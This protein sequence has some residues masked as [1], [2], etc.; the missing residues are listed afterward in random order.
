MT[1]ALSVTSTVLGTSHPLGAQELA[2]ACGAEITWVV[3]LVEVGIIESRAP[4]AQVDD[5]RF[6]SADLQSALSVRRLQ[7]D[8]GVDLDAAALIIDLK[9]EVQRL[10]AVLVAR[11]LGREI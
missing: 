4:A 9:H 10:R 1:T 8:F 2:H 7:R 6:E 5:W 3:Q 11:G